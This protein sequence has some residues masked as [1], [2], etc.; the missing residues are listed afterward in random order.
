MYL[1]LNKIVLTTGSSKGMIKIQQVVN[2]AFNMLCW[3]L[4]IIRDRAPK[5]KQNLML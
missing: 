3:L 2:V 1:L 5:Q 4:I